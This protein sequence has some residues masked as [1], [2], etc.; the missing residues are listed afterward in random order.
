M[1]NK[2][3][4]YKCKLCKKNFLKKDLIFNYCSED[5]ICL[6]CYKKQFPLKPMR[7]DFSQFHICL[8]W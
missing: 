6:R 5:K 7:S 8:Q 1:N 3:E 2:K 4:K